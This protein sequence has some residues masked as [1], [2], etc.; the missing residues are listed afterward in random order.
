MH[1][2]PPALIRLTCL[3]AAAMLSL[4]ASTIWLLLHTRTSDSKSTMLIRS[5]GR[6]SSKIVVNALLVCPWN[7]QKWFVVYS[8]DIYAGEMWSAFFRWN[9]SWQS[10]MELEGR[11]GQ[12]DIEWAMGRLIYIYIYREREREREIERE[13]EREGGR[14]RERERER[15]GGGGYNDNI[16]D[17]IP[18][19][20]LLL[21]KYA[22][23][24]K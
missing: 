19:H 9:I 4:V 16:H 14:E 7:E 3:L 11:R 21:Y 20:P 24:S 5:I 13:R 17:S 18:N 15:E 22:F 1:L 8:Y 12:N 2:P 6:T 10:G 23:Y